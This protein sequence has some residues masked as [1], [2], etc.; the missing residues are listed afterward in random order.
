[1]GIFIIFQLPNGRQV[2]SETLKKCASAFV[3]NEKHWYKKVHWQL[4]LYSFILV[5][6]LE[7]PLPLLYFFLL[8]L[9]LFTSV[10]LLCCFVLRF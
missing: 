1:M 7:E 4:F 3:K 10:Q 9:L 2:L 8:F 5:A 6:P